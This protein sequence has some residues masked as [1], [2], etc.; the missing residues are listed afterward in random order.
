MFQANK[1]IYIVFVFAIWF[2]S[3]KLDVIPSDKY[4]D[5]SIWNSTA[6]IDLYAYGAYSEF[7]NFAF[8]RFF[9]LGYNNA[10]DA[11]TDIEKYTSITEGNGTVNRIAFDPARITSTSP[12]L[13]YWS[14]AYIRIRRIN[15]FLTGIDKYATTL[16][17]T[18]KVQYKAEARFIRGYTYFWLVKLHGSVVL[19]EEPT[20][21]NKP[22]SSEDDCWNFIAKDFEYAAQNLPVAW[23]NEYEG[24]VT[25]GAAYGMLARTWL[26]AASI[27]E[28]DN[29]LYNSDPLTGVSASKKE[30][31]YKNA[32]NAA[33]KVFQ[34]ETAGYCALE[35]NFANVFKN[36]ATK[37]ALFVLRYA[38]PN[39]T[40]DY[41]LY[42]TPV[43]DVKGALSAGVP[44]AE[45]VDEF[46]MADGA[47]FSWTN[48]GQANNPYRNREERFYATILFNGASWK[49]RLLDLTP[50]DAVEGFADPSLS[51]DPKR[52]IT[53][54][55]IKK[56]LDSLNADIAVSK[57]E[58]PWIEMRLA[59][60]YLIHAEANAKL[61]NLSIAATSLNKIRN[62]AKLPNT[63]A[64]SAM[65]LMQAIEHER[66][67]ELAFEG[68]RYWDLRRW[69]KAHIVLNNVR[70]HGHKPYANGT[71][72]TIEADIQTRYFPAKLYYL[73]IPLAEVQ[74]NTQITQ[75]AG[76]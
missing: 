22:R 17:S 27:A 44:T 49:G 4:T 65:A 29:K 52:T 31:Y 51:S 38:R 62:R 71:F 74:R 7:R 18:K 54:Y 64:T 15:E 26:Y 66:I 41:D 36:R 43:R 24:R 56:N 50:N 23:A 8:G 14:T 20:S 76:W 63:T 12:G 40:H 46:E 1:K 72:E 35:T 11:F 3:C 68:H 69:R 19:L 75:I 13:N 30:Q 33:E 6:S 53:G 73:P 25:K 39:L 16:D 57:S 34:L 37:E 2:A 5:K 48:T 47:K 32:S 21:E 10:T 67:V 9:N 42:F 55:Y 60:V 58:Q 59:E 28:Y 70:F 45:L 61:N